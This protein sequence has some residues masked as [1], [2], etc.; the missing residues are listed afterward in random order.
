MNKC[1]ECSELKYYQHHS[2]K[3]KKKIPSSWSHHH[4]Q[5][6]PFNKKRADIKNA[7]EGLVRT[8]CYQKKS[9]K[10]KENTFFL[11]PSPGPT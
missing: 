1:V 5:H 9:G 3:K 11:E 6:N 2:D 7:I 10:K 8:K 4:Q